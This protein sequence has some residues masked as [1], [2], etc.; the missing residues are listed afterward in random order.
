MDILN[1]G[2]DPNSVDEKGNTALHYC[3]ACFDK[4]VSIYKQAFTA[5]MRKNLNPNVLNLDGWAPLHIAIKKGV[6]EA[7]SAALLHNT[8]KL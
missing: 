2:A 5:L 6:N 8:K 3:M 1:Q 7:V 4:D